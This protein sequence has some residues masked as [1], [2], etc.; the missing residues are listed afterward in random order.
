MQ[1]IS[2]HGV[3]SDSLSTKHT[4]FYYVDFNDFGLLRAPNNFERELQQQLIHY[5]VDKVDLKRF[6]EALK[7]RDKSIVEAFYMGYTQKE[8]AERFGLAQQTVSRLL[9]QVGHRLQR[10]VLGLPWRGE[11]AVLPLVETRTRYQNSN[12]RSKDVGKSDQSFE[13]GY[14]SYK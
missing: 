3:F 8:I 2:S 6:L 4:L 10:M 13:K 1:V 11:Y 9:H 12:G 7:P 14:L 5:D